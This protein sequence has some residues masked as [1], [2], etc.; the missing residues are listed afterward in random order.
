ALG[1][2]V[3]EMLT[4]KEPFSQLEEQQIIYNV[5]TLN[6]CPKVDIL[7]SPLASDLLT[8]VFEKDPHKRPCASKLLQLHPFIN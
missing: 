3:V 8:A 6:I 1:C 7:L 2:V 5:T 4:G